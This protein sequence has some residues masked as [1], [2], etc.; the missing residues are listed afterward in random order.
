[1]STDQQTLSSLSHPKD[2]GKAN[3]KPD[4]TAPP[5]TPEQLQ[6]AKK[7]LSENSYCKNYDRKDRKYCDPPKEGQSIGLFSFVP[8][9]GATPDENGFYGWAKLRGNYADEETAEIAADK[10][11]R[12]IDSTHL[13]YHTVVGRPFPITV[14]AD[15]ALSTDEVD[16]KKKAMTQAI[17][18]RRKIEKEALV[19][20]KERHDELVEKIQ[21]PDPEE[22]EED[23]YITTRVKKAQATWAYIEYLAKAHE[24]RAIITDS[25]EYLDRVDSERPEFKD[26]YFEKYKNAREN[27]GSKVTEEQLKNGFLRYMVEDITVPGLDKVDTNDDILQLAKKERER[28]YFIHDNHEPVPSKSD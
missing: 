19:E 2:L 4:E 13:I 22:L 24:F 9:V 20:S 8:A 11:I 14:S 7:D 1:M 18:N 6:N 28:T 17:K 12:D 10:I 27:T 21:N 3:W 25:S 15:L 16:L 5:L 26:M 23:D